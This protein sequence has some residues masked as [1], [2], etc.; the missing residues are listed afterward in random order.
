MQGDG[1]RV[2]VLQV[3]VSGPP[4][5]VTELYMRICALCECRHV[6]VCV[7]ISVSTSTYVPCVCQCVSVSEFVCL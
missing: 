7:F 3:C 4:G 2:H 5:L 6:P 1:T